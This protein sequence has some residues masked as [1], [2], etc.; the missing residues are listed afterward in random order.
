MQSISSI[1]LG[2]KQSGKSGGSG[3]NI[4]KGAATIGRYLS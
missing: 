3:K 4:P 1:R 2:A